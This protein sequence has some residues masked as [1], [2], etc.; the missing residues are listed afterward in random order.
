MGTIEAEWP[1]QAVAE[2]STALF[3]RPVNRRLV[4]RFLV[5][6]LNP[7]GESDGGAM[8]LAFEDSCLFGSTDIHDAEFE[9]FR[10]IMSDRMF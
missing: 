2:L 5:C 9:K 10:S 7:G 6:I 1:P 4:A 3:G 8:R